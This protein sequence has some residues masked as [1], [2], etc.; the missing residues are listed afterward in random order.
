[1]GG[2]RI[3]FSEGKVLFVVAGKYR[4][5]FCEKE[6]DAR[7]VKVNYYRWRQAGKERWWLEN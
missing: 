2:G 7:K 1:M 3:K 5:H 6:R 4:W